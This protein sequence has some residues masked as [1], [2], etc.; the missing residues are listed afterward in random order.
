MKFTKTLFIP[1]RAIPFMESSI[2][3][4]GISEKEG[5]VHLLVKGYKRPKSKIRGEID[6]LTVSEV[7]FYP[8][9]TRDIHT[10]KE[11]KMQETFPEIYRD[12]NTMKKCL[13][14]GNIVLKTTTKEIAKSV[15][16]LYRGLLKEVNRRKGECENSLYYGTL[17]KLLHS[18]GVFP[19][20][21]QCVRCGSHAVKYISL[22][23]GGPLC[24]KCVR[25]EDDKQNYSVRMAR[26]LFFLLSRDFS[27]ISRFRASSETFE[28]IM[29][30]V[31]LH[32]SGE[33]EDEVEKDSV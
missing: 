32:L 9:P 28:L 29:N 8:K 14:I 27:E 18:G 31:K 33:F 11:A 2:I 1:I 7:L 5:I 24:E 23:A 15:F 6:I 16:S 19:K 12:Y 22:R 3:F 30:M 4:H 13:E 21:S 20:L 26:E 17:A 25:D 10:V